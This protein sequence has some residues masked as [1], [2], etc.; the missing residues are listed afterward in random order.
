MNPPYDKNLHLKILREAIKH[1]DDVVNLSPIRWLQDPLAEYKKGSDWNTFKDVREKIADLEII[2]NNAASQMF[3]AHIAMN[4]GVYHITSKGG[5]ERELQWYEKLVAKFYVEK[6]TIV[7]HWTGDYKGDFTGNFVKLPLLH[8]NLGRKDWYE[9]TSPDK[10]YCFTKPDKEVV[11][12]PTV[13]FAT[14]EEAEN[15]WESLQTKFY[16]F[17][18]FKCRCTTTP[19]YECL[20]WLDDYTNKWT[21][22]KLYEHFA[23]T[24]E[25]IKGIEKCIL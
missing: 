20:P 4:L 10:S 11:R 2:S 5:W 25:E 21:D 15:F 23:L 22:E 24:D 18:N 14:K 17:I 3:N 12:S 13:N 8:G 6:N 1:S 9:T 16:K 19:A 7:N